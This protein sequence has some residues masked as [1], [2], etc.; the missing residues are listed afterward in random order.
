[1]TVDS[2]INSVFNSVTYILSDSESDEVWLV[3]CGDVEK[4]DHSFSVKG[5]LLTH[6]HFDHIYGLNTLLE[7]YPDVK[8]Y[9]NSYGKEALLDPRMNLS[10]YYSEIPDFIFEKPDS[11]V[12]IDEHSKLVFGGST[13][14]ILPV[15]GHDESCL[16]Y[17]IENKLFTG[18]AYIPGEKVVMNLPRCNKALAKESQSYLEGVGSQFDVF[19]G[20]KVF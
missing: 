8:I 20:H 18:D 17:R 13:I 5:V 9:T 15:P 2:I 6:T 14:A 12:A 16:A 3:D 19:P 11:V 10:R 4:L 7:K 1:M